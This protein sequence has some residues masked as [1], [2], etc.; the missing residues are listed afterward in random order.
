MNR[1]SASQ[2]GT[3]FTHRLTIRHHELTVDEPGE[4]GGDDL[5]PSPQEL[6]AASVAS[7][8][9]ITVE[10]YAKRKGW[11]IAPV[12]VECAY[13]ST[14]RGQPTVFDLVLRVP[15]SCSAEQVEKLSAIAARCPVH[16][17]LEGE[18]VF[19]ERVEQAS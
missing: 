12:E 9:A 14:E 2:A 10:M 3:T 16:R 5:G 13:Q 7:C 4:L 6:L 11:E 8:T 19:R 17:T 18:V 15:S 1:A